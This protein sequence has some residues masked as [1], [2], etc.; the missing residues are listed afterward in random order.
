[1]A[2]IREDETLVHAP[3]LTGHGCESPVLAALTKGCS[4][5]ILKCLL[6]AG[7]S[8]LDV[9]CA[10]LTALEVVAGVGQTKLETLP[11]ALDDEGLWTPYED[12]GGFVVPS[13]IFGSSWDQGSQVGEPCR[14]DEE[15]R[16]ACAALLLAH[17]AGTAHA[18]AAAAAS[19]AAEECG[20]TKLAGLIRYWEELGAVRYLRELRSRPMC[21]SSST[22][23]ECPHEILELI[24]EAL[25]PCEA[26]L[27]SGKR[28]LAAALPV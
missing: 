18:G 28:H 17:G 22:L 2:S 15:R 14:D 13:Q 1:M 26:T 9:G 21:A 3:L 11:N 5:S 25:V 8:F 24:C 20:Y 10:G 27:L 6:R 12:I 16:C 23:L 4:A 7:A 19:Q